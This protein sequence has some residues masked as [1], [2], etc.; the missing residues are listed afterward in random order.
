MVHRSDARGLRMHRV[1][2]QR[3]QSHGVAD[4][5]VAQIDQHVDPLRRRDEGPLAADRRRKQPAV[6]ADHREREL[7]AFRR[8]EGNRERPRVRRVEN[9]ESI[10]AGGDVQ[11]RAM[12]A[13][14]KEVVA[15]EAVRKVR[16]RGSVGA[17]SAA[18]LQDQRDLGT[19]GR[20]VECSAQRTLVVVLHEDDAVQ[21]AIGLRGSEAVRMRV[22]PVHATAVA[23]FE[24]IRI[25]LA[26][27][28]EDRTIAVVARVHREAMPVR[29]R[30]L[31][32]CIDETDP[33]ALAALHHQCRVRVASSTVARDVCEWP[34]TRGS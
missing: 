12:R 19:A 3:F 28:R 34:L 13:V 20:K 23:H 7:V 10:Q 4:R 32:E 2:C 9:S 11:I 14:D 17:T 8:A 29:D 16:G 21:A 15:E 26:G 18:V 33:H 1:E 27:R 6:I 24:V 31:G 25:A 30:R 22:V 5:G